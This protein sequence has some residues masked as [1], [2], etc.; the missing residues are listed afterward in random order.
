MSIWSVISFLHLL[1]TVTWIGG[2]VYINLVLNPSLGVLDPPQRGKLMGAVAKR[3]GMLASGSAVILLI[4][5]FIRTKSELLFSLSSPEGVTLA[6]KH[7]VVLSMLIIGFLTAIRI[8]P[9]MQS[10]A[11]LPGKPPTEDYLKA[12]KQ[13][14]VLGQV[15]MILGILSLL[16]TALL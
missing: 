5:G 1:G 11:P 4:T 9:K 10:L 7:L 15:G 14:S 3:F 2:M 6:L 16:L 8:A 13:I 12:Q